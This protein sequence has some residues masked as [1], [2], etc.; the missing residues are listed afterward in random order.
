MDERVY[1][2][3][4]M[5]PLT[6]GEVLASE[7]EDPSVTGARNLDWHALLS[8]LDEKARSILNCL[9]E[10]RPLLEI[11]VAYGISRSG[12]QTLKV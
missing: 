9:A 2:D 12:V 5:E 7:A 1:S 8:T 4:G 11:A 10:G 6:L 3:E